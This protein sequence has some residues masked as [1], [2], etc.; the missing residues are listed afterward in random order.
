M[1]N[2]ENYSETIFESIKHINE[3]GDEFWYARELQEVLEYKQW[4]RFNDT[5]ERAKIACEV[6]E[7]PVF[8]HF[9]EFGKTI[10]M[11][12]TAVKEITDYMLTRYACYLI[13]QNGNPRKKAIA[14]GQTYFAVK[15]R[16]QEITEFKNLSE[17]ERRLE[18]RN[19]V[20]GFNK[21]LFDAAQG[22]GVIN[23][24]KFYNYG[25][26][27]LYN[28]E[29]AQDIKYRKGLNKKDDVLDYMGATELAANYFRITQTEEKLRN[30]NTINTE[31]K[32][33]LTHYNVGQKVRKTMLDI[34]GTAPEDLPTPEK[35]IKQ[36]EREHRKLT[37]EIS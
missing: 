22:S 8:E 13:V 37:D 23:Y 9:A 20:K 36:I 27:G 21:K 7:I 32:A 5:I 18:L 24:G 17:D 12:K 19:S 2:I 14:L 1:E 35:S 31:D 6:S 34:S 10:Q 30:D 26:K 28:G 25:Y 33:N 4:R 16:Q 3:F 29:T 15:T 11:P